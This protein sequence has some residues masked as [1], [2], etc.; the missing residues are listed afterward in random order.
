[1]KRS[2]KPATTVADVVQVMETIAPPDLAQ[3][4]DNTGLLAGDTAAACR[5][6]LLCVDLTPPVLAEAM[7]WACDLIV[8]Y[9]PLL[10]KPV[11]RLS[12]AAEGPE[13]VLFRAIAAD[14]AVY[15]PHTA[16][17]A[18]PGGTNDVLAG[19][20]GLTEVEPFEYTTAGPRQSKVV[21]F[22]PHEQADR[23]AGAMFAAGAGR[24]GDYAM[25]SYRLRGRGTF[26]GLAGT[27]PR[28]G[29]KGRL[30]QVEE[31]RLEVI[32]ADSRLPEV[33]NALL[34]AHPYEEPAYDIYPLSPP[35][36]FGIGR[37]G[38]LPTGTTLA[39]LARR[40]KRACGSGRVELVGRAA[41]AVRR[42]AVCV[43]SAGLLPFEKPRSADCDVVVTGEMRHHDALTL[44]RN[45]RTAILLGHWESERPILSV[46]GSRLEEAL[47][48]VRVAVSRKDASPFTL[49]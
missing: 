20:C 41:T 15:C 45:G 26:F 47:R 34:S 25:C 2:Q 36:G 32:T 35:P 27:D 9:H 11:N 42:A 21:T 1:M 7:A 29:R 3:P 23:V 37:V 12:A 49:L 22:V 13:S 30:E 10:L 28:V 46:L 17:D 8:A 33:I 31:T 38:T 40:L 18:A 48:G 6:I 16:L 5:R 43:G 24:I 44:L 19:M 39:G 14:I 4:W